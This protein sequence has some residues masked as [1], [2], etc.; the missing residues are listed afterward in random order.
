MAVYKV[1]ASTS[2]TFNALNSGKASEATFLVNAD[3]EIDAAFRAAYLAGGM[4]VDSDSVNDGTKTS[5]NTPDMFDLLMGAYEI[6]DIL[7]SFSVI[8]ITNTEEK[9]ENG[10]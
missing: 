10:D 6:G 4:E 9:T 2:M 1:K 5:E 3:N 8:S 7:G